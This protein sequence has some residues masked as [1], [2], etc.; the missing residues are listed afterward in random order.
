MKGLWNLLMYFGVLW[1]ASHF[2]SQYVKVDSLQTLVIVVVFMFV[3]AWLYSLAFLLSAVLMYAGVGCITT[4]IMLLG[5]FVLQ[6]LEL[7]LATQYV[8]G[9]QIEGVWTYVFITVVLNILT[10][11]PETKTKE[12]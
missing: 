1:G 5:L 9:F 7:Y 8:P 6:P 3:F 10:F 11:H 12:N 2:F 4:P